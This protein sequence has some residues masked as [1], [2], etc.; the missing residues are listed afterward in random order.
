MTTASLPA[1]DP[2]RRAALRPPRVTF[3]LPDRNRSGGVRVTVE[4][5]NRLL[6]DRYAV[7]ILY[8]RRT[9]TAVT[10]G[11]DAV[12]NLG[13]RIFG[14]VHDDWL[15]S[16]RGCVE[17]FEDLNRADF[18]H[19]EVVIAVGSMV[20]PDVRAL[21]A[22]VTRVRFNHGFHNFLPD[23][24]EAAWA[25]RMP[26]MTVASTMI[27]DLRAYDGNSP[28]W[29]VPNGIDTDQYFDERRIRDGVGTIFSRNHAKCPQDVLQVLAELPARIPSVKRYVFGEGR[30]PAEVPRACYWQLP[31]LERA[32]ELYNRSKVWLLMSRAEGLPGRRSRR[33]PAAASSSAPTTTAAARSSAT[34]RTAY[35]SRSAIPVRASTWLN[36]SGAMRTCASG[37]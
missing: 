32:R 36:A 3:V 22:P 11:K 34:A 28:V 21:R 23:R 14:A 31:A 26:T 18:E 5:A 30:R 6:Q 15:P 10:R 1:F 33:W 8:R 37:W 4:M 9:M 20:V 35:C 7:R 2:P 12:R 13:R 27:P 19:D 24:M 29:V 25:G 16:F 17:S